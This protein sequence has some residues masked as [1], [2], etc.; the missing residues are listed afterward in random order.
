MK[1][2]FLAGLVLTAYL[3]HALSIP[4]LSNITQPEKRQ[5]APATSSSERYVFAHFMVGFVNSYT[6]EDWNRDVA[7]AVSKGIDGFALNC[8]GQDTNAQQLQFAFTAAS[9]SN[10]KLFISP[11]FVHYSYEDPGPVSELLKPWVTQASY[12][13]FEGK[14]FVSSFWGEGTDW[15]KVR[16]N[17]GVELYVCPYYYASQAAA[18]T[19]GL[20]GLFSW[21]TWPGEGQDTVVFENMTTAPDEEYL[22]LLA[23]LGKSYMA[24]V[25]PWF[26]SHLPASTGFPKNYHLYSD[27]LWPTRWQQIL[28]LVT[29]YPDQVKFV[30]IITW[31]DWTESSLITPYRGTMTTDGNKEWSEDFDHSAFMDM[32]GPFISAF[33]AGNAAPQVTENRI[34]WWYRPTLKAAECSGTDSV[35]EKPRGW[36]M[37]ADSV[38]VAALT[39]GPATVTVTIGGTA[40]SQQVTEAGVHTLAFPMSVGVVSFQMDVDGGGSASGQGTIEISDQCYRGMYNFNVLAGTAV[41]DVT[42]NTGGSISAPASS[43]AAAPSSA[44]PFTNGSSPSSVSAPPSDASSVITAPGSMAPS[45]AYSTPSDGGVATTQPPSTATSVPAYSGPGSYPP[46]QSASSHPWGGWRNPGW[47]P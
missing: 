1:L 18:D 39:T 41:A 37:A 33:K 10:F 38:F 43:A 7:L 35:G 8:D 26:Y 30:E 15:V 40:S 14:L 29:T 25:S 9:S 12:F 4:R 17:V 6:Q 42:S 45:S 5:A 32:M 24:P 31:N 27:T 3:T 11:D 20:D 19:P 47:G 34:V 21:R 13:Q 16:E 22:S 36:E 44:A 28:D 46:P 2:N 23:P